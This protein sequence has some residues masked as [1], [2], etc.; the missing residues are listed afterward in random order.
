[1]KSIEFYIQNKEGKV[2]Q[3]NPQSLTIRHI[4][5]KVKDKFLYKAS[6]CLR[7]EIN[8]VKHKKASL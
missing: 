8:T 2:M 3:P 6:L 7:T 4:Y 1:M 5:L